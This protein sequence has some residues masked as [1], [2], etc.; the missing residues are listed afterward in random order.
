MASVWIDKRD[1]VAFDDNAEDKGGAELFPR[2]DEWCVGAVCFL[3]GA[4]KHFLDSVTHEFVID[5]LAHKC[6]VASI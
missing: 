6:K 4:N 3:D 5:N 2:G 1:G